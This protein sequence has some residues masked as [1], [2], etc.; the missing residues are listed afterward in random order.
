[1]NILHFSIFFLIEFRT[2][3]LDVNFFL[4]TQHE[5]F[6]RSALDDLRNAHNSCLKYLYTLKINMTSS[7]HTHTY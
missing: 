1:M 7:I 6:Q 5:V 3:V 4:I 2:N